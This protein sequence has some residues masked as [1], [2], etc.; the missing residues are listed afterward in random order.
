MPERTKPP[1]P[2]GGGPARTAH[3][4]LPPTKRAALS[5]A[6]YE[7]EHRQRL[8]ARNATFAQLLARAEARQR[9]NP[10]EKD[11]GL[12]KAE[13]VAIYE[14]TT[15][16]RFIRDFNRLT[17]DAPLAARVLHRGFITVLRSALN[18]LD[19][20]EGQ[21]WRGSGTL[22]SEIDS[23]T[24]QG[25]IWSPRQF[26]S[27]AWK[28]EGTKD[29]ADDIVFDIQS[30]TGKNVSQLSAKDNDFEVLFLPETVFRVA[31]AN[32]DPETGKWKIMLTDLGVP[33]QEG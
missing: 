20:Y 31:E 19:P 1:A 2:P 7:A 17:R 25:A 27:T 24:T 21:V 26:W 23:L 4:P 15:D 12:R 28:I 8:V 5:E 16:S 10:L 6:I 13:L 18:K 32:K 30:K 14:Y 11:P 9:R 33:D 3:L 29:Y 22:P